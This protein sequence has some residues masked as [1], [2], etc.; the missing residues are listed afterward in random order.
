[1]AE[2]HDASSKTEDA[3]S[4]KLEEA[5]AKGQVVQSREVTNWFAMLGVSASVMLLAPPVAKSL[6]ASMLRF[7][8][9]PH[10]LRLDD[11][12]SSAVLDALL[13]VALALAA[14]LGVMLIIGVGSSFLQNGVV[15]A[16]D[17]LR[18]KLENIS[19]LKGWGRLAS[20]RNLVEFGKGIGKV[21]LVT[22]V[23]LWLLAPEV[24]RLGLM[25]TME[26]AGILAEIHRLAIRLVLG[27]AVA[28][29]AIAIF[30]FAYQR[31]EFMKSMRMSR[32]EVKEE[33]RQVEGDPHIKGKLRQI[34]MERAR[35][36]MMMAVPKA[37]VVITNPTHFAV[38]LHYELGEQ[39]A[40]RLVAKGADLIAA[41]IREVA[42]AHGVP[43][44]ENPPLARALYASVELDQEI[45][46]EHYKAVAE[47]ISY[48]FRLK[49]KLK[50]AA[51]VAI[52]AA[53]H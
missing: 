51:P 21:T 28:L 22:C 14:P 37:S 39:S 38:A 41:K 19:P 3:S 32:Q 31:F 8:E 53:P 4:R 50:P 47:I 13:G 40:P 11:A 27:V 20:M 42:A 7:I 49:G 12:F 1:M 43:V 24:D 10:R 34:R 46:T 26:P 23:A 44:V 16:T 2:E 18:P 15:F 5:R 30:D 35:K 9:E 45:P 25:P 33:Y 17:R 36:R 48:V 52:A 29:A 6:A